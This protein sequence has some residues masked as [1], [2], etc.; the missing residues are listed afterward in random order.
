MIK[1]PITFRLRATRAV[2]IAA[3]LA[4]TGCA[5]APAPPANSN[6][7]EEKPPVVIEVKETQ[8]GQAAFYSDSFQGRR[9]YSGETFNNTDMVAAHPT[10][11]MGTIVRVIN[12]ANERAVEVRVIDR[13]PS[14][15]DQDNG[16][17][18]DLSRSAAELLDFIQEG[19]AQVRVEVLEWG[20]D[21]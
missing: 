17:I 10:Y 5:A 13:G 8:T 7:A 1:A 11:P 19:M 9:T 16:L 20:G 2:A 4:F 14:K 6:Q 21:R 3:A 18:I 15:K 12:L